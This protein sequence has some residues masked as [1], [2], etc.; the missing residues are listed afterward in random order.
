MIFAGFSSRERSE[1]KNLAL[2]EL[3]PGIHDSPALPA[4]NFGLIAAHSGHRN[5]GSSAF[6]THELSHRGL[7]LRPAH[8][9]KIKHGRMN[10]QDSHRELS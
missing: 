6:G 3:S 2:F 7:P 8:S 4:G 10:Q 9:A 1:I 5:R